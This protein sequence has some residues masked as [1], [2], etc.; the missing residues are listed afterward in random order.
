MEHI[1]TSIC[2]KIEDQDYPIERGV[3]HDLMWFMLCIQFSSY[4]KLLMNELPNI[5]CP[6]SNNNLTLYVFHGLNSEFW[7]QR[8]YCF[9]LRLEDLTHIWRSI[10][11]VGWAWNLSLVPYLLHTFIFKLQIIQIRK[12]TITP[13]LTAPT[14]ITKS[15]SSKTSC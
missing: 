13:V 14:L 10:W 15:G 12:P 4:F 7:V 11:Y 9:D 1:K 8:D 2:Q 6:F 5:D 3:H